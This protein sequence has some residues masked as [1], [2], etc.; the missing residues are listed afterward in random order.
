MLRTHTCGELRK[1][2]VGKKV[3]LAGWADTIRLHGGVGFIDLR[4]RYG[5]IQAVL[6]KK[7]PDFQK[8]KELLVESCLLIEGEVVAR[9]KGGENKDIETGD[10]EIFVNKLEVISKSEP[11]PFKLDGKDL[12]QKKYLEFG[13]KEK[14]PTPD[15]Y[16]PVIS[17]STKE[18]AE[19]LITCL[20]K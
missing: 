16:I 7:N 12:G 5:K 10:I 2:D 11:I 3:K 9:Q 17:A 15:N 19:V 20:N 14:I 18:L 6:I 1:K 8:L 13:R 4:D